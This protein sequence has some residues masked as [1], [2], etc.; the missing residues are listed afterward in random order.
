[1]FEI[2]KKMIE[3]RFWKLNFNLMNEGRR[4]CDYYM[5]NFVKIRLKDNINR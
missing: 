2:K 5:K 1:M 3:I 4:I